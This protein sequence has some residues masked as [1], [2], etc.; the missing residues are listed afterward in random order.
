MLYEPF[1]WQLH[2]DIKRIVL[3]FGNDYNFKVCLSELVEEFIKPINS[4]AAL[5]NGVMQ[6]I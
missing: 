5:S 3:Y 1:Y 6:D 4:V 2:N